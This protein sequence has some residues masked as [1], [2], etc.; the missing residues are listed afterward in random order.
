MAHFLAAIHTISPCSLRI[1]LIASRCSRARFTTTPSQ[2]TK[3]VK[4]MRNERSEY[5]NQ[6]RRAFISAFYDSELKGV[7]AGRSTASPILRL[8]DVATWQGFLY[9]CDGFFGHPAATDVQ[10]PQLLE[11]TQILYRVVG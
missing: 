5:W 11:R 7:F 1:A 10:F 4:T 3:A 9:L 6:R 8:S 2:T